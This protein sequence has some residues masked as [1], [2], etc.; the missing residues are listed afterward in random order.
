M[1]HEDLKPSIYDSIVFGS[2][3]RPNALQDRWFQLAFEV[4]VLC[5]WCFAG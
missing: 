1:P 4:Q 2:S 5:F 3:Q